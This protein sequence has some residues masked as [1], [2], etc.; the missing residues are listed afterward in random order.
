VVVASFDG[1]VSVH[2]LQGSGGDE[3]APAAPA[4][5]LDDPFSFGAAI[6]QQ[7]SSHK[8]TLTQ[9]P[10]WLRRPVG[11]SWGFGG[12][13]VH[14]NSTKSPDGQVRK[15]VG[16]CT[17]VSEPNFVNRATELDRVKEEQ[18]PEGFMQFCQ[19]MAAAEGLVLTEKDR[20][21]WRFLRV[22][23]ETGAREQ[24]L[25][26]LGFDKN[27][28]GGARLGELLKKLKIKD[29]LKPTTEDVAGEVN[30]AQLTGEEAEALA[31]VVANAKQASPPTPFKLYSSGKGEDSD[32]DTLIMKAVILGDFETAVRVC[33][34]ANRLSDALMFAV[35]GGPDLL[36]FAQNEYFKRVVN[37]KAYAR[38]LKSVIAG[39]L[40][41]VIENAQFD[42]G[43]SDWKDLLALICTYAKTED[44][45]ELMSL[46]GRRLEVSMAPTAGAAALKSVDWKSREE[47][48]FAAVLCYLGAGD[49]NK[50]VNVWSAKE[51]EEEKLLLSVSKNV[52]GQKI[53]R[54]TSHVLALQSMIEKVQVFRQAIGY[55]D[56]EISGTSSDGSASFKLETLYNHYVD[57]AEC[58]ANQGLIN[59][60]WKVLELVPEGY[61]SAKRVTPNG[62]DAIAILKD[63]VY[64][65]SYARADPSKAPKFPFQVVNIS[66]PVQQ[67]PQ[68][69]GQAAADYSS[70]GYY[71]GAQ[72]GYGQNSAVNGY[73]DP[74]YGK[75]TAANTMT[76]GYNYGNTGYGQQQW[77][78]NTSYGGGYGNSNYGGR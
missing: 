25:K 14:F 73:S 63:R 49:I 71:S 69:N 61:Q 4:V 54:Y 6:A 64:Q 36:A 29:E 15:T 66:L 38:V 45:S 35:C 39:D 31:S 56:T 24:L 32:T 34:G 47:R 60:A 43:L 48:K 21:V 51:A 67:Q 44:L 3:S 18:A 12:K 20:E 70:A 75:P 1:K 50:V 13:L 8:F 72:S 17:V 58:V 78:E 11:C 28:I 10:K 30:G 76:S 53:S 9:P 59:L 62:E 27:D 5:S 22:M 19:N 26:F 74:Y 37:D 40:R 65:V 23:F 2:S 46:L 16:I 33:F 7:S 68:Q 42:A 77:T 52:N 55:V 57:Y 41:D